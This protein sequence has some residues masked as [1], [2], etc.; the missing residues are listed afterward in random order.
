MN[1]DKLIAH[2]RENTQNL[3][4]HHICWDDDPLRLPGTKGEL[5]TDLTGVDSHGLRVIV[6]VKTDLSSSKRYQQRRHAI[7]ESITQ[8]LNYANAYMKHHK[9]SVDLKDSAKYLRL[10]IVGPMFSQTVEDVC[11]FLRMHGINICHISTTDETIG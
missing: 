10:F 11:E 6:E 3:F 9:P 4:G 5:E 1:E 2:I 7:L 8:V